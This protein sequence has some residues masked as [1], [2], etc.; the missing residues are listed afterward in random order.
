MRLVWQKSKKK[1]FSKVFTALGFDGI[2]RQV[3]LELIKGGYESV[4]KI[5]T[6]ASKNKPEI[7]SELEGFGEI[8]A[9]L[10]INH[11]TDPKNLQVISELKQLGLNFKET[12]NSQMLQD[13]TFADQVWVI[14]GTFDHFSRRSKAAEE[15]ER[16]GGTVVPTVSAKTS[17]LLVGKSPG[18]KLKKA[19]GLNI[20]LVDEDHF[21]SIISATPIEIS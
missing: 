18:S 7:F 16:R 6:D 19:E 14:T 2:G 8:M 21:V 15:I 17:H 4:D 12:I 5:I 1:P 13:Q 3:V 20:Q 10:L 11:F 9:K